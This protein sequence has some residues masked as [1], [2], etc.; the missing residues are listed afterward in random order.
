[1]LFRASADPAERLV[2]SAESDEEVAD[3]ITPEVLAGLGY[4]ELMEKADLSMTA[5]GF[6]TAAQLYAAAAGREGK[7]QS[8]VLMAIPAHAQEQVAQEQAAQSGPIILVIDVQ[9]ILR[10]SLA[11]KSVRSQLEARRNKLRKEFTKL[12]DELRTAERELVRQRT[13]LAPEAFQEKRQAYE[14]RVAAAQRMFDTSRRNLDRAFSTAL[15]EIQTAII[16]VGQVIAIEMNADLVMARYTRSGRLLE[17]GCATGWFLDEARRRGYQV[18][19]LELSNV[20]AEWGRT[21]LD[22]PVFTGTLAQ[23]AFPAASF[24]IVALRHVFEHLSDPFPELRE[25]N[26]VLE[27]GGERQSVV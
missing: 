17:S 14:K 2:A 23:A 4:G 3:V 12:E 19:G 1:M 26:P 27:P 22:L 21:R 5:G 24:D 6:A 18:Q 20:A 8:M 16:R 15:K 11:A 13:V 25:I 9:R 10:E 7:G